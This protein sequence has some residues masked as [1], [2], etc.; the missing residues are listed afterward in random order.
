[1]NDRVTQ[2]RNRRLTRRE[3]LVGA[4]GVGG[5]LALG[6]VGYAL[7]RDGGET[8]VDVRLDAM[9][10]DVKVSGR[11]VT[12]W[13]YGEHLPGPTIRLR[14][15][16]RARIRV[17]NELPA[18]TTVH[19]H[20]IR[21]RNAMDGVP[22]LTQAPIRRGESFVYDFVPPDAGTYFYHSHVGVQLDR[23]L[24]GP[25]IVDDP[26]DPVGADADEVIVVDDWLDGL[27]STPDRTFR[28][29]RTM[30]M[31]SGSMSM[32]GMQ[33]D[34]SGGSGAPGMGGMS[35]RISR[36]GLAEMQRA[37]RSGRL[38][39]VDGSPPALT[40]LAGMA[41]AIRAGAM[42]GGDVRYPQ[43]LLNGRSPFD[44]LVL[45]A[46]AGAQMRVRL[47][48]AAS[49]TLYLLHLDGHP[50]TVVASD[51]LPVEPVRAEGVVL[52][53]GERLDFLARID[54]VRRLVAEPLGKSGRAVG[55]LAPRGQRVDTGH[56]L[57]PVVEPRRIADY[58]DL[59]DAG[60]GDPAPAPDD[61]R[62]LELAMSMP[63]RWTA[64]DT[65]GGDRDIAV[66]RGTVLR[67]TME[68]RTTMPHPMHLHGHSFRILR[69]IDRLGAMKDTVL[70][71]PGQ[72][73][74][75][76]VAADNPG[77]WMLHCHNA[78]HLAAGMMRTIVVE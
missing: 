36:S 56:A 37:A 60:S 30:G 58:S 71:M 62:R 7:L 50:L 14:R 40:Q 31:S 46:P 20:G 59:R 15:G 17:D 61:E 4:A 29:L 18:E 1:M 43:H 47:I 5:A 9:I 16:K 72:T 75:V 53:I 44:P 51:G 45:R 13:A 48:N 54:Q 77:A 73:L 39:N 10:A 28:Q 25:L 64:A 74:S 26:S 8:A 27:G 6:G 32:P 70:V 3:A 33:M 19:W 49:D 12:T 41:N 34:M 68:N 2:E 57:R 66:R 78:Y 67:L 23:G 22:G 65:D 35:M 38:R 52:G 42:D 24:Y 69:G 76:D 21:L 55:F 11:Q 63:Y